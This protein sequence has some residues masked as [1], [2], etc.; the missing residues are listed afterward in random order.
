MVFSSILFVGLF[1]PLFLLTYYLTP[2]RY[3][4]HCILLGS[5]VFYAWWRID[6]AALLALV[7][8]INYALSIRMHHAVFHKKY[9]LSLAVVFNL[10]ILGYFKYAMFMAGA[11]HDAALFLG[12]GG[13]EI[14]QVILPIGISFYIFQA[15]SYHI[16]VYRGDG[17]EAPRLIDFAAYLALFPQLIAG[18]IVRYKDIAARLYERTHSLEQCREGMLYFCAGFCK[19]VLIAD[20]LAP[21][22]DMM[23]VLQHPT[24]LESWLGAVAYSFQLY[25]DFLGYSQMA[26]GLGMMMGFRFI[27]NFNHPY[28][29]R[30]ITEF[31]QRWHISLSQWLKDYL[32]I[33]LGGNR[34]GTVMTYRNLFLTMLLGGIWHGAAWTFVI[35]GAWHGVLLCIERALGAKKRALYP[36]VVGWGITML[37][38]IIGWVMFRAETVSDA[39]VMYQGMLGIHGVGLSDYTHW[40]VQPFH[41]TMLCVAMMVTILS[42]WRVRLTSPFSTRWAKE[43]P[44]SLQTLLVAGFVIALVKLVAESHSP[45]LYFQF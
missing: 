13:F 7:T 9:V 20:S 30:S 23:F 16:D 2:V 35:W 28:M 27:E 18:P 15:I 17:P 39:L 8:L 26:I 37:C 10:F 5:Y 42:A 12:A 19:K 32:Y 43:M 22:A 11:F 21:L 40:Q 14:W 38:V 36:K 44:M 45:F 41:L 31:W 34:Y 29:S 25:F 24:L 3:R 33:P 4:N 1:L 6:F